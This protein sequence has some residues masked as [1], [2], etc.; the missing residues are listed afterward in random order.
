MQLKKKKVWKIIIIVL[1]SIFVLLTVGLWA[2][3][4]SIYNENFDKRFES[5]EPLMFKVEDFEGLSRNKYEFPS[6]K[7]QLL[8]GYLYSAGEEQSGV[9]VLAHGFG[10]GGHNSY[11]DCINYFAQ[12]GYY[13]FAYDATGN[14]ESGGDG[15]GG[16]PQ[17]VIDLDYAVSFV[18]GLNELKGLPIGLFGYSW[19][20]YSV[21][22]A[23]NYH[24]E[25][26]AVIECSGANSSAEMF[27]AVGKKQAGSFIYVMMPFVKLHEQIKYGKYASNTALDGFKTSNAAVMVVHST[28]DDTI[29]IEYGFDKYYEKYSSDPR[30]TFLKFE[31]KGHNDILRST[32]DTYVEEVNAE[33]N[34]WLETLDYDYEAEENKDRFIEDRANYINEHLDRERWSNRLDEELFSKFIAFYDDN[35]SD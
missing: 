20:G 13:V 1:L 26:K 10:S 31:D 33:F 29:P 6:D 15:V 16:I 11:M 25:V 27:E 35:M 23:L 12:H 4:V 18:E 19:G 9:I 24:P 14:D 22:N 8:A 7:G 30:F 21:C 28:D 34:K 5:Y 2:F 32:K 3:T 17:G